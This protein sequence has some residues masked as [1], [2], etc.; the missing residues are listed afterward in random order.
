MAL[1]SPLKHNDLHA[2]GFQQLACALVCAFVSSL[3][4]MISSHVISGF[5]VILSRF[6]HGFCRCPWGS[7]S[8]LLCDAIPPLPTA[9]LSLDYKR[10]CNPD[11]R[12]ASTILLHAILGSWLEE[13]V[14][15]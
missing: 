9:L 8:T 12:F 10:Q 2:T 15:S 11:L 1:K 14:L 3:G 4:P 6:A 7:T 13:N 5:I